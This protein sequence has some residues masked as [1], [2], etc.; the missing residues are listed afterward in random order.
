MGVGVVTCEGTEYG[1][2]AMIGW[3]STGGEGIRGVFRSSILAAA[4]C[5][6]GREDKAARVCRWEWRMQ[7]P[8]WKVSRSCARYRGIAGEWDD[9]REGRDWV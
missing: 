6:T 4:G 5:P 9:G 1:S 3:V 2:W 7:G 8:C